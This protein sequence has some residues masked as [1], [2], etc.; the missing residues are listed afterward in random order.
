M[1]IESCGLRS[2]STNA[3]GNTILINE[4][5]DASLGF[6]RGGARAYE[7]ILT[8]NGWQVYSTLHDSWHFGVFVDVAGLQILT[9]SDCERLLVVC[10][11]EDSFQA[12]LQSMTE[13]YGEPEL[14]FT[15]ANPHAR[16]PPTPAFASMVLI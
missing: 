1:T 3:R 4:G 13:F 5:A 15:A 16:K 8:K 2:G 11:N 9:Y 14:D 6:V 10:T 12:E 7:R